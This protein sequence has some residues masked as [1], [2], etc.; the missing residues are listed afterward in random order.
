M[1]C[2]ISSAR[3]GRGGRRAL[4]SALFLIPAVRAALQRPDRMARRIF[5]H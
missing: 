2:A 1:I 5:S 3:A 4:P